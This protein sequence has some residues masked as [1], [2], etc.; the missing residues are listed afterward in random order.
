MTQRGEVRPRLHSRAKDGEHGRVGA[1]QQAPH[2]AGD[3]QRGAALAV[4]VRGALPVLAGVGRIGAIV[5]GAREQ[6]AKEQERGVDAGQLRV[7]IAAAGLHIEEMVEEAA[8]AGCVRLRRRQHCAASW[9][10]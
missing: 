10:A 2:R 3:E 5:P 8:V 6:D 4:H 1:G 7:A 9:A